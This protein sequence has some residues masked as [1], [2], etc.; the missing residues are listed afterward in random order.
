MATQ[1]NKNNWQ[2]KVTL[3]ILIKLT[4]LKIIGLNEWRE[5]MEMAG[6]RTIAHVKARVYLRLVVSFTYICNL[7]LMFSLLVN[8]NLPC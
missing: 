2:H 6:I 5:P 7:P 1:A 3:V 8:D 4:H